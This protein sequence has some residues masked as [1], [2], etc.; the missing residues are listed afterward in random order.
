MLLIYESLFIVKAVLTLIYSDRLG[1]FTHP[2]VDIANKLGN[3]F[4][5]VLRALISLE[6]AADAYHRQDRQKEIE[7]LSDLV[8]FFPV[9]L[10]GQMTKKPREDCCLGIK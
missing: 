8:T 4:P 10:I 5:K 7:G 6:S 1:I 9:S 3:L 2:D